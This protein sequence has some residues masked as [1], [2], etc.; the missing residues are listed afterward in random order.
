MNE[1]LDRLR[2]R[3]VVSCQA[4]PGEPLRDPDSMRRMALA[5]LHGGAAGIRA[6]G[7]D[8][9]RLIRE[10]VDVPIIG[11]WKDGAEGVY[12]TPT[13]DHAV[14]VAGTGA[15][16]VAFDAT[17]RKRPDGRPIED[18]VA[19]I[20]AVGRL[21]MADVS[22]LEE[23]V[24]AVELGADVVGTTLSGYTVLGP[25]PIGPDLDLVE[26]LVAAVPVPVIAE[27]RI[28][29]PRQAADAMGR[30]AHSVVVG[31]AITHPTTITCWF[32]DAVNG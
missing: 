5:A 17:G 15:D 9:L 12:I 31:T 3:L 21:A 7:L 2:G 6:Q 25:K 22:A 29:T 32:A 27:G 1:V 18:T 8:D 16:V 11:L 13:A 4:Y 23:G 20:H 14:A 19:A 30:G 26:A 10:S 28:H 24:R